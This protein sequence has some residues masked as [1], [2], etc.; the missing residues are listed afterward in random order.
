MSPI[1][2][3]CIRCALPLWAG[4]TFWLAAEDVALA[5]GPLAQAGAR[6]EQTFAAWLMMNLG[7]FGGLAVLVGA[8][9]LV[10]A[11]FLVYLTRRPA[12]IAS[13]LVFLLLPLLIS[14][15][16]VLKGSVASFAAL[17]MSD[18]AFKQSA[19]FAGLAECA[20]LLLAA[21]VVTLPAYLVVAVG[22]FVRTIQAGNR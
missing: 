15:I 7:L 18:M 14:I 5:S 3:G 19:L 13:Y 11:V 16:G 17:G 10:G 21:L 20:L 9:L 6:V 12:V 1:N 4:L 22:L 2:V 8:V